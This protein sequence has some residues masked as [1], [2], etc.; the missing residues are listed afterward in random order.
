MVALQTN[1][2]D[3]QLLFTAPA[4]PVSYDGGE[5]PDRIA[6]WSGRPP[7]HRSCRGRSF[8]SG[9]ALII[10]HNALAAHKSAAAAECLAAKGAWFL[11]LPQ[12]SFDNASV[13]LQNPLWNKLAADDG[14]VRVFDVTNS[15]FASPELGFI[16]GSPLPLPRHCLRMVGAFCMAQ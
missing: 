13:T 2:L 6:R 3:D 9:A 4:M 10:A 8:V 14:G 15:Y 16:S 1:V 11:F 12:G 5:T 7:E